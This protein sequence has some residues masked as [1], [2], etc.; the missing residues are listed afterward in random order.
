MLVEQRLQYR[1]RSI[2]GHTVATGHATGHAYYMIQQWLRG[3]GVLLFNSELQ[4]S[5]ALLPPAARLSHP[6]SIALVFKQE[7]P[8]TDKTIKKIK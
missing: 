2:C 6:N 5:V 8:P 1:N 3:A 7:A 4:L